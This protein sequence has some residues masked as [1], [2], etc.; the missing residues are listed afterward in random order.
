MA[1]LDALAKALR[2]ELGTPPEAWQKAQRERMREVLA[3]KPQRPLLARF[4]PVLALSLVAVCAL[5]WFGSSRP[6]TQSGQASLAAN[7]LAEP[8]RLEDGSSI[9]LAKGGR[10]RLVSEETTVRFE[11]EVGRADFDVVPNQKRKWTITAGKN[12]VTVIGTRFSVSYEPSGAFEVDVQRGVV[13]VRVPERRASV[14]LKAGDHLRGGPGRMEVVQGAPGVS[15]P[16]AAASAPSEA[17]EPTP[18]APASVAPAPAAPGSSAPPQSAEWRDRYR[19]GKYAEALALL[20]ASHAAERLESLGPRLLADIADVARLG[21][22]LKL[23]A[24]ALGVL[25]R[26]YPRASEARD[27][28]FLLGRVHALSGDRASAIRAFESYLESGSSRRYANEAAG[29]LMDLYAERGD[30]ERARAMAQ[31]YLASA[32]NGPYRRL[33]LSLTR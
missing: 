15:E 8:I 29:R 19:D 11:L 6:N 10:G 25:L 20:R 31:R 5:V 14:E 27:A 21:G 33:A 22:D 32:P 1:D 4:A 17:P 26:Q 30:T 9:V 23:A 24:R 18:E 13:S 7:G 12:E 3:A 16:A 28:Q 2:N